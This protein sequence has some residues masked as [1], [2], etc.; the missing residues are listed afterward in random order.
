[1][2]SLRAMRYGIWAAVVVVVAVIAGTLYWQSRGGGSVTASLIGGPFTLTDQHGATVTE[3]ALKGHPSALFFGYTFC[4]DVCPTTLYDMSQYLKQLGPDGDK[5]KVY[6]VTV[7]PERDTQAQMATYLGSF[8][9]RI[10]GLT[11]S[12]PAI[13]Q[14]LKAY[15]IYSKKV[16]A[17]D[18][19]YSM[20]HAAS[21]YLLDKDG[22]FTSTLDYQEKPDVALAKLKK[23]VAG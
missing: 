20:D 11:G 23:L 4:P 1:M 8:D 2:T 18:G 17:D 10:T 9:P 5:L 3:A 16:P 19:N 13:D 22:T 6:F 14:M 21:V 15:R 7:D 12:R